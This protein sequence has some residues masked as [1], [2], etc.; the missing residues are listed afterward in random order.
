MMCRSRRTRAYTT[1]SEQDDLADR[2]A[3]IGRELTNIISGF[4]PTYDEQGRDRFMLL[5]VERERLAQESKELYGEK[6][7]KRRARRSGRR[8]SEDADSELL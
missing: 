4:A 7:P 5:L 8:R 6:E 1:M 3:A 2:M